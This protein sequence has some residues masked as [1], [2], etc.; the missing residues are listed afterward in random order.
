MRVDKRM[1]NVYRQKWIFHANLKANAFRCIRYQ[2]RIPTKKAKK[3]RHPESLD[4]RRTSTRIFSQ[5]NVG[6]LRYYYFANKRVQ[7][8]VR[9]YHA[10]AVYAVR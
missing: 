7:G 2:L 5:S 4:D 1:W 6:Y 8:Y 10:S 3:I 9:C